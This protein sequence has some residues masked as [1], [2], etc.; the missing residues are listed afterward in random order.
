MQAEVYAHSPSTRKDGVWAEEVRIT[1]GE[2]FG[3]DGPYV[4]DRLWASGRHGEFARVSWAWL[5]RDAFTTAHI[6]RGTVSLAVSVDLITDLELISLH[7]GHQGRI[8]PCWV[9]RRPGSRA[10]IDRASVAPIVREALMRRAGFSCAACGVTP[11]VDVDAYDGSYAPGHG[12]QEL[13]LDHIVPLARG[14]ADDLKNLQVLCRWCNHR[15]G[16]KA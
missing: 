16:A 7:A 12:D 4:I 14:G 13:H 8:D 3:P 2:K 9:A 6:V 11:E 1:L 15:K 10:R 5:A